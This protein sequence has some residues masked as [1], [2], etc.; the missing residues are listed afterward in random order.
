MDDDNYT[1]GFDKTTAQQLKASVGGEDREHANLHGRMNP[2]LYGKTKPAGLAV[3]TPAAVL[4]YDADG[5]LTSDELIAETRVTSIPGDTEIVLF[6]AY[7]RW[8]ALKL[9]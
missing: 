1:W 4:L 2:C 8:L 7:G 5:L 6:S 3:S 9:C